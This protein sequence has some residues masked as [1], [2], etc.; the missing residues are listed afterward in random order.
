MASQEFL[1]IPNAEIEGLYLHIPFCF[2]KCHYCDF[3]SIVDSP[4]RDHQ[5][6]FTDR[7][8]REWRWHNRHRTH[9]PKT[10]FVGGGTPTLLRPPLWQTLLDT[11]NHLDSL[12]R[13]CEFTVEANPETVT[14]ELMV[15]LA[16]GGV[17]R[18]SIGAQTF[19]ERHLKTL[20]RWHEPATV[21]RAVDMTRAAGIDNISLDLIFAV[22]GQK[23]ADLD[24][25]LDALLAL[26]PDHVSCY[27]LI[28]EPNT[29]LT[30]KLKQGRIQ[31]MDEDH[32][33]AMYERVID[34][35]TAA[36]FE[37]YEIS[38]FA[39]PGKHCA[40]NK[41][42]WQN[43]NW[44]GIGPSAS[45]H[46]A[47][48]RWKNIPHLGQY[49]NSEAHGPITDVERLTADESIGEQLMMRLRLLEGVPLAW[50]NRHVTG[51]RAEK[52]DGFVS[53]GLLERTNSHVRLS[54]EGLFVAD[55]VVSELL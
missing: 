49:L 38:N 9:H 11:L 4:Q 22:P 39:K 25:D 34:R 26:Q 7:L 13:V 55:S 24:R 46:V 10:I 2:H 28:F 44:L 17:N 14:A 48:L 19:D 18:V 33:R 40:H 35:L 8:N 42:Y 32:E 15:Q 12:R 3:Y 43:G 47:G 20:E 30:E 54:R 53:H 1:E 45:S 21:S 36:G 41:L 29:P 27:S 50:V 37:H 5:Q 6:V 51:E 31:R 52:I 16:A 23:L